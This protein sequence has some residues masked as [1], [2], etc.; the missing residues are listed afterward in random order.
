[1]RCVSACCVLILPHFYTKLLNSH[2]HFLYSCIKRIL[3]YTVPAI[4]ALVAAAAHAQ[5]P[6]VAPAHS[7]IA[8]AT[9]PSATVPGL[10]SETA[11]GAEAEAGPGINSPVSSLQMLLQSSTML[12]IPAPTHDALDLAP[13]LPAAPTRPSSSAS[14]RVIDDDSIHTHGSGRD[15]DSHASISADRHQPTV[16]SVATK[17]S[18][19]PT[20][21]SSSG[22]G[23]E[24]TNLGV[25]TGDGDSEKLHD[26][27]WLIDSL[28]TDA[29]KSRKTSAL[30]ELKLLTR[31]AN[32]AYWTSNCA[33]L[34]S[35]LLEAFVNRPQ[36]AAVVSATE[37]GA[38]DNAT[39][40]SAVENMQF[41]CKAL[42][43]LVKHRSREVAPF[44][45][46]LASKLCQSAAFAPTAV[47]LHFEQ[48]LADLGTCCSA[49]GQCGAGRRSAVNWCPIILVMCLSPHLPH[50]YPPPLSLLLRTTIAPFD[51]LRLLKVLLPYCIDPAVAVSSSQ[52]SAG[53]GP[54]F[55]AA[56]TGHGF[57]SSSMIGKGVAPNIRLVALHVMAETLKHM[58]S[59]H[60]LPGESLLFGAWTCVYMHV[61]SSMRVE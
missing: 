41:S 8:T 5:P 14:Y 40:F 52:S 54:S 12:P 57:G 47:C 4:D 43:L 1:M 35:V 22:V 7:T 6:L 2:Y 55:G 51:A 33:Q 24:V 50:I 34:I 61:C 30:R 60:L 20:P 23:G 42:L 38:D 26:V 36:L 17:R 11:T 53:A 19:P 28:S 29:P 37:S 39:T 46:L 16:R 15:K 58:P 10:H 13:G 48:I 49:S 56:N 31:M 3:V 32:D 21:S 27:V 25:G 18:S 45:D 44:I 9:A 59:S